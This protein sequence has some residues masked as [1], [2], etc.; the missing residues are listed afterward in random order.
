MTA[1]MGTQSLCYGYM[2]N[3]INGR[4]VKASDVSLGQTRLLTKTH[5]W[6][7]CK[8]AA[9]SASATSPLASN[10]SGSAARGKH[11][12]FSVDSM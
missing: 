8:L 1:M 3:G 6:S 5:T 2:A 4:T 12:W 7:A 10:F 9:I 11:I